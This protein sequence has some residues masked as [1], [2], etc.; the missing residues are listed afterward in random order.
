[1]AVVT[2]QHL[3]ADLRGGVSELLY[4]KKDGSVR[5]VRATLSRNYV[6]ED[7]FSAL[8]KSLSDT[9][10]DKLSVWDLRGGWRTLLVDSIVSAQ[11]L[12]AYY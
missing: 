11:S 4:K 8:D 6:P 1:M 9:A 5:T 12:N 10:E 2:K 3:R 7:Q